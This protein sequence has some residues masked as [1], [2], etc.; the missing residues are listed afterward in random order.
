MKKIGFY[1]GLLSILIISSSTTEDNCD[2]RSLKNELIRE[3]RPD[4]KYD[5]SNISRFILEN[6]KQGTEVQV[7]IFS[8]ENYRLLFNT[9]AIPTDFEI[10]IYNKKIGANNRKLLFS[11]NGSETDKNIFVFEPEEAKTMYIDY[12]LPGVEEKN[13]TGCIVFLMGYKIG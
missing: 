1:I 9:S 5:S 12:I 7:P 8:S 10:K 6:E 3:L 11:V 2:V 4:F 13:L